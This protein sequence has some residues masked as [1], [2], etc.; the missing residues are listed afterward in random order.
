MPQHRSSCRQGG[1]AVEALTV[2]VD[3]VDC[4][5]TGSSSPEYRECSSLE[6]MQR[7]TCLCLHTVACSATRLQVIPY[8]A[9]TGTSSIACYLLLLYCT[10]DVAQQPPP[11][12]PC[13]SLMIFC[14]SCSSALSTSPPLPSSVPCSWAGGRLP[15]VQQVVH[16]AV[17]QAVQHAVQYAG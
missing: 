9:K 10:A 13:I 14:I 1:V 6:T 11:P 5:H 16:Q 4:H 15:A 3:C 8:H 7:P 17:H 12:V 2:H